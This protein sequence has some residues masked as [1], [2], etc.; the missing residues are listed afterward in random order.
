MYPSPL[1]LCTFYSPLLYHV[2]LSPISVCLLLS[3]PIPRT[4]LPSPCMPSI[5]LSYTMH[6]VLA[7]FNP[8]Y[9]VP[10]SL[11]YVT[12]Y[13]LSYPQVYCVDLLALTTHPPVVHLC[14]Y[15]KGLYPAFEVKCYQF[16][17]NYMNLLNKNKIKYQAVL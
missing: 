12:C 1:S 5:V 11:L 15:I 14:L 7:L 6:Y 13:H 3:S 10:R 17:I 9:N 4:P 16:N 2:P 8:V